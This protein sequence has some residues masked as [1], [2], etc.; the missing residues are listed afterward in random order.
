LFSRSRQNEIE[1]TNNDRKD[2][3]MKAPAKLKRRSESRKN[4]SRKV[5]K[6]EAGKKTSDSTKSGDVPEVGKD[7]KMEFYK[8]NR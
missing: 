6:M 1:A 5:G 2:S 3:A 8:F 4:V 7:S